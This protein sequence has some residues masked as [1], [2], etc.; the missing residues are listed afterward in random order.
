MNF[1]NVNI[2]P[3]RIEDIELMRKWRNNENHFRSGKR[4]NHNVKSKKMFAKLLT[5]N[6]PDGIVTT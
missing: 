2:Q 4:K 1:N 5:K 3:I 6:R